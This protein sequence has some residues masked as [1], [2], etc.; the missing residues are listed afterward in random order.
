[1]KIKFDSSKENLFFTSDTHFWHKNI[2]K[3]CNRPFSSPEEMNLVLIENWNRVVSKNDTVFHLGDFAFCSP[4][5]YKEILE[6]LNGKIILILGNHDY[7]NIKEGYMNL[8][9]GVYQQL[10]INVDGTQ[11]IYLNHFPFLCFD[12]SWSN[13]EQKWQL[14]G[15]VHSGPRSSS[16]LDNKRLDILFPNQYDVGVDNNDFTPVSY[17]EIK[18]RIKNQ[19]KVWKIKN[20]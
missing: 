12:G 16:G 19:I 5:R 20:T 1:M 18:N 8:F 6:Q 3:Y 11:N 2:I 7:R 4:S 9:E 10:K 15:H 14:F 17:S 13:Q